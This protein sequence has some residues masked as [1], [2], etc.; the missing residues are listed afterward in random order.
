VTEYYNFNFLYSTFFGL[1]K[2]FRK[3]AGTVGSIIAF[4]I[5]I[6][7][8]RFSHYLVET[9]TNHISNVFLGSALVVLILSILLLLGIYSSN[10]YCRIT[11]QND[12]KEIIIDEIIGQSLVIT[13]TLPFTMGFIL[14]ANLVEKN[15]PNILDVAII[16]GVVSFILF[17]I[18]DIFKPWP[19][20][21]LDKN[22]K[23]GIGVMLDDIAAAILSII[24]YYFI[25]FFV[26]IDVILK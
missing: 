17:R 23:G 14:S 5:T 25:L 11:Q 26:V 2:I 3:G 4:P 12:P 20:N 19:I 10:Q 16:G 22:L 8:F 24:T 9:F 21:Y 13:A 6:Y 1:G 18:F 15:I 7:L